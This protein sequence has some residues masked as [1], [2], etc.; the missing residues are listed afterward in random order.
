MI[1]DDLKDDPRSAEDV[2]ALEHCN[3]TEAPIFE[4]GRHLLHRQLMMWDKKVRGP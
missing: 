4:L 2:G 3:F 1:L